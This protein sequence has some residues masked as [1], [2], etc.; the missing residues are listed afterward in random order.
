MQRAPDYRADLDLFVK[1][2][3]GN[4]ASFCTVW[5]DTRNKYGVFEPVGTRFD[6]RGLGLGRA[7][8]AEGFRR[9]RDY[10]ATRSFMDSDNPFYGK[11]GFRPTPY[12]YSEWMRYLER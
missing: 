10:G 2:P 4:C 3:N 12:T 8:L 1:A 5:L 7:L 9:M 11:V 6:Y